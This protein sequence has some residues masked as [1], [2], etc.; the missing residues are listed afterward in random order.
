[1]NEYIAVMLCFL[2]KHFI[3]DFLLQFPRHYLHKGRYGAWGGIE[4]GLIHGAATA[5]ILGPL[6]GLIDALLHYHIDWA[7]MNINK[8]FNLKPDNSEVFW[9]MIGLDQ[10]MHYLTYLGL[11]WMYFK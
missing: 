11:I 9:H 7:K 1:M 8:K 6:Y 4:H 5:F 2:I 3:C 10:L